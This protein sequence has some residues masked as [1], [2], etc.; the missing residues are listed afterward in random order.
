MT[1]KPTEPSATPK[2]DQIKDLPPKKLTPQDEEN[3][4][5]GRRG[6]GTQTEDDVYV[7]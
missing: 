3:T 2:A 6:P 4:K 7:G 1:D 5:G